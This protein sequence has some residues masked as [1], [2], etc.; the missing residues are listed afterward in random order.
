[1]R[2]E[3]SGLL[4][5]AAMIALVTTPVHAE[6]L[7]D[8]A[9]IAKAMTAAPEAVAKGAT[10]AT[11][12]GGSMRVLQKGT[13]QWTCMIMPDDVPMCTDPAGM[14]WVHAV[15]TKTN[16][17][18][19]VGFIYMLA[20]DNGTSN[21]APGAMGPTSDNHW[22]K[23]GPHVMLLGPGVKAMV[24]YP[25]TLDADPTK[26]YVM[27]PDTPYEHLMIPVK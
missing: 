1:M 6:K 21:V 11:M 20:G 12:E 24:S 10:I 13:N 26:P 17:P 23:T 19:K 3:L 27:W 8:A 14:E 15:L 25:R 9:Y 16:P 2:N 7:S 5:A 18:D 22:V 4:S